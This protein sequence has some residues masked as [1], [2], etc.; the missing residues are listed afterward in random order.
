MLLPLLLQ[1]L[2]LFLLAQLQA[3]CSAGTRSKEYHSKT[4]RRR[5]GSHQP[6]GARCLDDARSC[7]GLS[8]LIS[9]QHDDI[10][11][12]TAIKMFHT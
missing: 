6:D 8:R 1:Q 7:A 10:G 12:I 3:G 9:L 4:L 11:H 5:K 2:L